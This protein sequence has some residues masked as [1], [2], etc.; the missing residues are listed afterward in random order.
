MARAATNGIWLEYD[1]FGSPA[2]DTVLLIN[3]LGAQMTRW[4]PE[5]CQLLAGEGLRP[6]RFDNRDIGL[7][8][9]FN[10]GD[11]YSLADMAADAL[12]LLDALGV[13]RA[14]FV[15]LSM[16]GMIAQTMAA[17][18]PERCLSL[19]SIMSSSGNP[20]LPPPTS[21]AI[22][23]TRASPLTP[24]DGEAFVAAGIAA[25]RAIE[26][27]SFPWDEAVIRA[28]VIA[29][30]ERA[31]HPAG[32]GRQRKA[33]VTAGDR[34]EQLRT[35]RAPTVVLHGVDDPLARIECGRDTAANI[36]GAELIEVTGMGHNM[37]PQLHGVFRDAILRAVARSDAPTR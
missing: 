16:G 30:A 36:P 19:T 22:A 24:A 18:R 20:A 15:G 9:W 34:R 14:H 3:G 8:T 29:E 5:F 4:T 31:F 28:R 27:P 6:V 7:S 35:I 17:S 11:R 23:V 12:G 33:V 26:S 13:Q 2:D 21:E 25:A 1:S 10:D 32:V 37:P